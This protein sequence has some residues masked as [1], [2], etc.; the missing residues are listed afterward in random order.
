MLAASVATASDV[1]D[2]LSRIGT[3]PRSGVHLEPGC[4]E[5]AL[6]KLQSDA[7]QHL[8]LEV[9]ASYLRMLRLTDGVQ[10]NGASFKKAEHLVLENLDVP[11]PEI[12]VLGSSGNVAE[13][14]FDKRDGRFHTINMGFPDERFASFQTFEE[15]LS[16]VMRE[17]QVA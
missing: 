8:G 1:F 3:N 16:M 13:Y 4:T 12:I 11:R 14:V 10:I 17:Q 5:D 15:M 9:P 7:R 6:R 2:I